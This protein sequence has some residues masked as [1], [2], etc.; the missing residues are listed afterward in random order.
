MSDK[1][2]KFA[3]VIIGAFIGGIV[4]GVPFMLHTD[5]K[6]QEH[7]DDT[8]VAGQTAFIRGICDGNAICDREVAYRTGGGSIERVSIIQGVPISNGQVVQLPS[9]CTRVQTNVHD[10]MTGDCRVTRPD[11]NPAY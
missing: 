3:W 10:R 2:T 11:D 5:K 7:L 6:H 1:N 8:W 9:T 4:V